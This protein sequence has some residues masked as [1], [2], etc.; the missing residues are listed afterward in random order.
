M[1]TRESWIY[2]MYNYASANENT[3]LSYVFF[4]VLILFGSW[5]AFNLILAQILDAFNF[6][7][8]AKSGADGSSQVENND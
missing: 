4:T 5:F 1:C 7:H 3:Y 8:S 2:L 6:E